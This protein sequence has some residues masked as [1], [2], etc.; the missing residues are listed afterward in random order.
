MYFNRTHTASDCDPKV[1]VSENI[2]Q[3]VSHVK[4]LSI[5]LCSNLSFKL[6]KFSMSEEVNHTEFVSIICVFFH[7][8]GPM[9]SMRFG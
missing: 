4:Y 3:V 5:M 7:V 8:L 6:G 2:I 1:C 9:A